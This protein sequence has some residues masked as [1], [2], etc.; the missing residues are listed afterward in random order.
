MLRNLLSNAVK[1]TETGAVEL[2]IEVAS[3]TGQ[4]SRSGQRVLAFHVQ[5]TGIGIPADKLSQ[6]FDAFQQADGTTSRKY[7]GTGLGLSISREIATL[8]GGEINAESSL[9]EGST[10][11]FYLP[12]THVTA[13]RVDRKPAPEIVRAGPSPAAE[14][15]AGSGSPSGGEV[16]RLL[17]R[18]AGPAA[19]CPCWPRAWWP[20]W[21][22]PTA[23]SRCR[24]RPTRPTP[25]GC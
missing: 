25:C 10:F 5:D 20:T 8:L 16:R 11:T 23:R 3:G 9:G 22:T 4:A 18:R 6:I 15:S 14:D 2:R 1:F 21:P 12:T 17:V 24:R 19:C 13:G 7:G